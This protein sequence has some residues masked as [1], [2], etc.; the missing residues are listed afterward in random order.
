[1]DGDWLEDAGGQTEH[2]LRMDGGRHHYIGG[3]EGVTG[4]A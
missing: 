1:M 3:D 4:H 2:G